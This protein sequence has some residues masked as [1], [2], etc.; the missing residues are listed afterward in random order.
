MTINRTLSE[1]RTCFLRII[2]DIHGYQKWYKRLVSGHKSSGLSK[3]EYTIQVG[4]LGFTYN[5]LDDIDPERHKVLGGNHDNYDIMGDYPHFLGDFGVYTIP[6]FGDIFFVR[7]AFSIDRATRD[8][9]VNWWEEEELTVEQGNAAIKLYGEVKPDFVITHAC[10]LNVVPHVANPM[11]AHNYGFATSVI[12]TKT[13]Q[14]LQAM[15]SVHRPKIHFFGH[16]HTDFDCYV[17]AASGEVMPENCPPEDHKYYT[18]FICVDKMKHI[19][20]DKGFQHRMLE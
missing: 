12:K 7:G 15:A 3:P 8:I 13:A 10:P 14:L 1:D 20:L 4:D 19:D 11:I 6:E 2:G 17:D 5:C 16:Y 18:R 9:G